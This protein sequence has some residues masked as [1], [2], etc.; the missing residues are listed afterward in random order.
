MHF[1]CGIED[2]RRAEVWRFAYSVRVSMS[3]RRTASLGLFWVRRVRALVSERK[4]RRSCGSSIFLVAVV[5]DVTMV[6]LMSESWTRN[7]RLSLPCNIWGHLLFRGG[8]YW[9]R[10]CSCCCLAMHDVLGH[11]TFPRQSPNGN[12]STNLRFE[13]THWSMINCITTI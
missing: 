1:S 5:A 11:E 6:L 8:E 2:T 10:S 9:S 3:F 4:L 12:L 7:E 13:H